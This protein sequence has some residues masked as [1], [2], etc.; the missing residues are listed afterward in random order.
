MIDRITRQVSLSAWAGLPLA[1]L[2]ALYAGNPGW[3]AGGLALL[4]ALLGAATQALDGPSARLGAGLAA[5]G[6]AIALT[7]AM[8]GH[9][10]QL[11]MHM[12]FF[13]ILAATVLLNDVRVIAGCTTLIAVHHLG[14]ALVTPALVYP[15][16]QGVVPLLERTALHA[17]VVLIEAG[18]LIYVIRTRTALEAD[19]VARADDLARAGRDADEARRAAEA[20]RAEAEAAR[21]RA[22]RAQAE[23]E[24]SLAASEA[25]R[26]RAEE[27]DRAVRAAEAREQDAAR[28]AEA[29]R[30][31]AMQA[32][33]RAMERLAAGDLSA[34]IEGALPAEYEALR[35]DV[36]GAVARMAEVI[37]KV[38]DQARAI[39][40]SVAGI[41]DA[42]AEVA[43]RVEGQASALTQ[44][45]TAVDGMVRAARDAAAEAEGAAESAGA[46]RAE[47]ARSGEIV[48]RAVEAM[49]RIEESA[50]QIA[51]INR[52]IE[53]IAFQTNL[54][55]L[56]A[57]VEA[58][59]AGE[60]GR[61]FAVVASEVR[62]LAGRASEA[63]GEIGALVEQSGREVAGGVDLV[64]RT[65]AALGGIVTAIAGIADRMTGVARSA[66]AQSSGFAEINS[67]IG[68]IDREAQASATAIDRATYAAD[69]LR[70]TAD[71]LK[72]AMS[73]FRQGGAGRAAGPGDRAA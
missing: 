70:D 67:A 65:G 12:T 3:L 39:D 72:S 2:A 1:V 25:E 36:D 29:E 40:G 5:T 18:A 69:G 22:E 14:F 9:P 46:A 24:R 41:T 4:F 63:A 34:R 55:A 38:A 42:A 61:G 7:A 33:G 52:V 62:A 60:A 27:T 16:G 26:R 51:R 8:A 23:A 10:W 66:R 13:A 68:E 49:G 11:D 32:I 19:A 48:A 37:G 28:A 35:A 58:A 6:Q 50:G 17:V 45:S 64:N 53:D 20:A 57:G 21:D 30:R 54:L 43:R 59:R 31:Q 15:G 73:A 44:T 47:A 71:A 56:N